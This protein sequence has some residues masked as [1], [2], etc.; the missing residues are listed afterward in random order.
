MIP[1]Y[2]QLEFVVDKIATTLSQPEDQV[3][4][5]VVFLLQYPLGWFMHF[6][7]FGTKLRHWF[8]VVAGLTIQIYLFGWGVKHVFLMSGV[9]YLIMLMMPR[10]GQ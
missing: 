2:D 6:C 9:T 1:V 5:M 10:F 7:L 8:N 3:R 4:L